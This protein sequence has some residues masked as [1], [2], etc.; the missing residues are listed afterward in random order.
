[1]L[2]FFYRWWFGLLAFR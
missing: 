1:M 2:T